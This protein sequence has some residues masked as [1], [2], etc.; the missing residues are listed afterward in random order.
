ME[1]TR[2]MPAPD[3]FTLDVRI[4]LELKE[5]FHLLIGN[6]KRGRLISEQAGADYLFNDAEVIG[7]V[8]DVLRDQTK[9]DDTTGWTVTDVQGAY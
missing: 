1:I 5:G 3:V 2:R 9:H 8:R 4:T 6:L 7:R